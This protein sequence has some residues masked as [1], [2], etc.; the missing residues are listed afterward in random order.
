M[1]DGIF[2]R[3]ARRLC[4]NTHD[5]GY[6]ENSLSSKLLLCVLP[7]IDE[8]IETNTWSFGKHW[9]TGIG[10]WNWTW[11]FWTS[12][13]SCSLQYQVSVSW[14]LVEIKAVIIQTPVISVKAKCSTVKL[15]SLWR[16]KCSFVLRNNREAHKRM[17]YF[18]IVVFSNPLIHTNNSSI[19]FHSTPSHY[20]NPI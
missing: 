6:S 19:P 11:T 2:L 5:T 18:V 20:H 1:I 4:R 10:T 15:P 8:L 3:W 17:P 9:H 7:L 13:L 12:R 14:S 16:T